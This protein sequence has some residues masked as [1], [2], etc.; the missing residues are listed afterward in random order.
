MNAT[1]LM[2]ARREFLG[3]VWSRRVLVG[4]WPWPCCWC[5]PVPAGVRVRPRA[6]VRVGLAGQAIALADGL[7]QETRA[8]V[9][10]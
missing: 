8:S 4:S 10:P 3:R 6:S 1:V 9:S 2:V 5:F 7:P